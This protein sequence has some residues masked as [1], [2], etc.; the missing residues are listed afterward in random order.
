MDYGISSRDYLAR[1]KK[2]L[3]KGDHA[4]LFYAAFEIRCGIEAR[5][6]EYLE[7]QKHI[8]KKQRQGWQIAK[9]AKNIENT[10][11]LGEKN[12]VLQILD[13]ETNK[14]TF[15]ARYTPVK[16]SL[17]KRGEKLGNI[18]HSAKKYYPIDAP[19]WGGLR[20]DLERDIAQLEQATSGRLLGP[21]L[22]SPD[23]K[24]I[25]MKLE[26]ANAKEQETMKK[27]QANEKIILKVN[28]E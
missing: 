23:G 8:S 15:E 21:L 12:A 24:S 2:C 3:N 18:L 13:T 19:F 7:A 16:Q 10:F 4:S 6:Q 14:V 26:F 11:K 9:L 27:F 17:R 20:K 25:D 28:Y 5:M 22:L 1:A